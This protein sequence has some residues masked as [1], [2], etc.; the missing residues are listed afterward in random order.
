MLRLAELQRKIDEASEEMRHIVQDDQGRGPQHR[1][2]RQETPINDDRWYDDMYHGNFA[3][4]DDSPLEAELQAT[5]WPPSCK[6]PQLPMYDRH[7]DPKQFL[8]SY[9]ATISSYGGNTAVMAKSFVM[10]VRSVAQTWYSSLRPRTITSWQKLKDM[11]VT[12]FQGFQTKP[13]TAQ[14]L[15]QCTQDHEEYLQAYVRRF[16]R[17]RAQAPMVPNKI[18]IEAMMKGLRPGPTSQYFV[19]KP[20]QILEKLLQKMDEYIRADN[21]FH[22]RREKAYTYSE[23]TRGFEGRLHP[24]HVRTIHNPN[25]NDDRANH[26]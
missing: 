13:V 1:E 14:A 21:D 3:F 11:L 24:R 9:E 18:V 19:R 17:L 26:T 10:A 16:L 22:Q 7:S 5:P 15:F 2:L 8:M 20:P 12:S 4:D 23:M 25:T 6:P